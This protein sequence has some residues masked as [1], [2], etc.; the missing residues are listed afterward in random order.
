[1][2]NVIDSSVIAL[3]SVITAGLVSI[4]SV[5]VPVLTDLWKAKRQEK[6]AQ[7]E[8]IDKTALD[9][10]G[11][12]APVRHN[13]YNKTSYS[14]SREFFILQSDLQASHYA[15]ERAVW[16]HL[17]SNDRDRVIKLRKVF[18]T[19]DKLSEYAKQMQ[20]LSAEILAITYIANRRV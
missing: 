17:N 16:G 14:S 3:V 20:E 6:F 8:E 13:D 19:A 12:I 2:P 7:A 11:K 15:W 10:L 9:L 5:F 1:M 18:E 4:L